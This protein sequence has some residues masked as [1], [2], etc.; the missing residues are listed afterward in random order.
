M[1]TQRPEKIESGRSAVP[2]VLMMLFLLRSKR[3]F[4]CQTDES[5]RPPLGSIVNVLNS[6]L[7]TM[8]KENR[9]EPLQLLAAQLAGV[10][11]LEKTMPLEVPDSVL[12]LKLAVHVCLKEIFAYTHSNG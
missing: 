2:A 4:S 12:K 9:I 8:R 5:G 6:E 1:S 7:E 10:L 11:S 3:E